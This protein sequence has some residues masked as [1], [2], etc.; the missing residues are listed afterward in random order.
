M[1]KIALL[2]TPSAVSAEAVW[3]LVDKC[4]DHIA[5]VGWSDPLREPFGPCGRRSRKILLN[6][7][8]RLAPYLLVSFVLPRIAAATRNLFAPKKS[9]R[10]LCQEKKIPLLKIAK[11]NDLPT[12]TQLR[13]VGA[14]RVLMC[15]FDQIVDASFIAAFPNG[16]AN[17]HPALLPQYRGAS[18]TLHALM[19]RRPQ[20]GVTLHEV[21]PDID[22][23]PI[24]AQRVV[25]LADSVSAVEAARRLHL[26]ALPLIEAWLDGTLK[27]GH[28]PEH[29]PYCKWPD[30]TMLKAMSAS[31]KRAVSFS[32]VWPSVSAPV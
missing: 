6:S 5:A 11:I 4:A 22:C 1:K 15:H 17:V 10:A 26:A 28:Q 27:P 8:F 13:H 2:T 14:E 16:V 25:D 32:D 29:A 30:A 9:L 7:H 24:W 3:R 19:A 21:T 18:P 23:G 31:G 20:F 12:V